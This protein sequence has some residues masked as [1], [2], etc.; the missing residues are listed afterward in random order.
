MLNPLVIRADASREMGTGHI[1]RMLALSHA[2]G[3][4]GGQSVLVTNDDC[5]AG[6]VKRVR[7][8]AVEVKFLNRDSMT[9]ERDAAI[10]K[11]TAEFY[12][13]AVVAVD[14]YEFKESYQNLLDGTASKVL[15]TDDYGHC[16][17]WNCDYVLNQNLHGDSKKIEGRARLLGGSRFALLRR[18][19]AAGEPR[20]ERQFPIQK[21]LVSMGGGDA[22]NATTA[23]ILALE[24][25]TDRKLDVLILIGA[26]N[27]HRNQVEAA[28][29][30][31]RHRCVVKCDVGDMGAVYAAVD[32]VIC[33]CGTTCYE[34]LYFG[35]PAFTITLADNQVEVARDLSSRSL[36]RCAGLLEDLTP[37]QLSDG[38]EDWLK[39]A[40]ELG[41]PPV[42]GMGAWRLANVLV[43]REWALRPARLADAWFTLALAN[44]PTVR[45]SGFSCRS[46]S[47]Q[48]H[49][50][51]FTNRLKSPHHAI[52]I[53]ERPA[54]G[55]AGV[56]RA[57]FF[58]DEWEL[59]VSLLP[60]ARGKGLARRAIERFVGILGDQGEKKFR[61]VIKPENKDSLR[62]FQSLGFQQTETRS[63]R[64]TWRL[65][66]N[67]A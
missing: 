7:D 8:A 54:F 50:T 67:A 13:A 34:W 60:E 47:R 3:A 45:G 22:K 32:A 20:L 40:T 18:E 12:G 44:E 30:G 65:Q 35:L 63:D 31:S 17:T 10:L 19:L 14:G 29:A 64:T 59:G 16:E 2:W 46:I 53:I 15:W 6:L 48:E 58:E 23:V 51:W 28:A 5:P 37:V 25:I 9:E 56:V 66:I 24:G 38:L 33:G 4:E 36:A 52:S 62:L 57:D 26:V 27:P 41:P 55:P 61:A 39:T 1:M 42:D 21:V 49:F 43:E 11:E